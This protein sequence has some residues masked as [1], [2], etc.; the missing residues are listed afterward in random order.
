[1]HTGRSASRREQGSG[2][3]GGGD[4]GVAAG[5]SSLWGGRGKGGR[6]G[7]VC[8]ARRFPHM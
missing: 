3:I 1:M 8:E 6:A 2:I 5:A 4:G 7:A